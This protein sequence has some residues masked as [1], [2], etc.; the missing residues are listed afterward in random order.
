[1]DVG[2]YLVKPLRGRDASEIPHLL[3]ESGNV[4]NRP[5]IKRGIILQLEAVFAVDMSQKLPHLR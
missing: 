5:P 1:M 3:P 2:A 4:V